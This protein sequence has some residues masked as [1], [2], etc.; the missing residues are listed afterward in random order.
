LDLGEHLLGGDM[1]RDITLPPVLS[2]DEF[3]KYIP[4]VA[5]TLEIGPYNR[6]TLLKSEYNVMY[7]DL[8]T[9]FE[10]E[11]NEA[12]YG[13]ETVEIPNQIDI[14]VDPTKRPSLN[15]NLKFDY[16][17]SAHNIE[18]YPDIIY[19]LVE[20]STLAA[21]MHTKFFLTVPDK[22]FCYDHYQ[23]ESDYTDMI[24]AFLEQRMNHTFASY[25]RANAYATHN[26]IWEHWH[27]VHGQ[28][29]RT[30]PININYATELR[31]KIDR[32]RDEK[33]RHF[34][35]IHAWYFTPES[36]QY[37]INMTNALGLQPWKVEAV[38]QPEKFSPEF[39]AVLSL[40]RY[41]NGG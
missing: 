33:Q 31:H 38:T 20:M 23:R 8:F 39:H 18:H 1:L 15:T 25:L 41:V 27:G 22:R 17:Y 2:K 29:P 16:L 26:N 9:S 34:A 3:I 12:R 14:L 11:S 5:R 24:D 36:F 4:K 6:P 10:I 30:V 13:T 40:T 32:A 28:D 37:N 35:D 21:A 7:A 19:H